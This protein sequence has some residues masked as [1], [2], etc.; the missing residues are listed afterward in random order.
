MKP[1]KL[2]PRVALY[3]GTFDPMTLGHLDVIV[4]A[5][6]VFHKVVVGIGRSNK[7]SVFAA[8][9]RLE[10]VREACRNIPSVEVVIFDGLT[11]DFARSLGINVL[12]RGLRNEGDFSFELQMAHMNRSLD[13]LI[14]T[15]FI[16]TS[17]EFS[18]ISSSIV[19]D[20]A[21]VGGDVGRLVPPSVL[22]KVTEKFSE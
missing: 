2:E 18:H 11:V 19:R 9:A 16:P 7:Q 13:R 22:K 1:R 21:K 5:A 6:N 15:V 3:A 14:D 17:Q 10:M 8:S 12:V 4:R 20:I